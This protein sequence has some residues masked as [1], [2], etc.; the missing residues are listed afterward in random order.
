MSAKSIV[1]GESS[2]PPMP[3]HW[4]FASLL[5]WEA[6]RHLLSY[7]GSGDAAIALLLQPFVGDFLSDPLIQADDRQRTIWT[8]LRDQVNASLSEELRDPPIAAPV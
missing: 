3:R 8:Q 1:S 7:G 2:L 4:Q 5:S 6:A